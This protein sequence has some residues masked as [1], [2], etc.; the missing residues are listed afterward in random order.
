[1]DCIALVDLLHVILKP[2]HK[3]QVYLLLEFRLP[4]T[5]SANTLLGCMDVLQ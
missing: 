2:L 4:N 1:M 3:F 5:P